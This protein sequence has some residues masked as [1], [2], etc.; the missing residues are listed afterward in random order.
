[1]HLISTLS[2]FFVS[3]ETGLSVPF[4]LS[5][6]PDSGITNKGAE[7]LSKSNSFDRW[8]SKKNSLTFFYSNFCF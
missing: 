6:R 7:T 2:P 1:M 3:N 8:L 4:K 5:L